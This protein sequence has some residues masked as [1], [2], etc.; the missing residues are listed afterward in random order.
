MKFY[1]GPP[2]GTWLYDAHVNVVGGGDP[3]LVN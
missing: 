2:S 3:N 1:R